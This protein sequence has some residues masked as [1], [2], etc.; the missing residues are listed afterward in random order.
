MGFPNAFNIY[1]FF[2]LVGDQQSASATNKER[3]RRT[4]R[5]GD[6]QTKVL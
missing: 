5:I 4:K 2:L 6:E 1:H 3:R